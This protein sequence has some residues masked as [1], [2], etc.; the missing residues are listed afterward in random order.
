MFSLLFPYQNTKF[1]MRDRNNPKKTTQRRKAS[2]LPSVNTFFTSEATTLASLSCTTY[3]KKKI[4]EN[5]INKQ[6]V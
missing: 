3:K 4:F 6:C 2:I 1:H 5:L